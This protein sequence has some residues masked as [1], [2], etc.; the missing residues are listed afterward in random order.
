MNTNS[1]YLEKQLATAKAEQTKD[2]IRN[3]AA[4][5]KIELSPEVLDMV[6]GGTM[7]FIAYGMK[8]CRNCKSTDLEVFMAYESDYGWGV[9]CKSC[10]WT[11]V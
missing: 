1:N 11:L 3:F 8:K 7:D 10:G 4:K 5:E 9:K 2:E 6:T